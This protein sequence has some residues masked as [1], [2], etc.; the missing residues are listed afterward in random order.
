MY[1]IKITMKHKP[2]INHNDI[3]TLP[4]CYNII[5]TSY[6]H[7][8]ESKVNT[9]SILL[10][11]KQGKL[12]RVTNKYIYGVQDIPKQYVNYRLMN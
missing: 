3:L 11:D 9:F 1:N 4:K 2:T 5:M 6:R 12:L 7:L 10:W 8:K